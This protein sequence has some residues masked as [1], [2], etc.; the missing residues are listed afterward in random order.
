MNNNELW[1]EITEAR[2]YSVSN[3]G[4]IKSL[5]RVVT[6]S[7]GTQITINTKILR[8]KSISNSGYYRIQLSVN[9]RNKS[10]YIHRLVAEY[11]VNNPNAITTAIENELMAY[12]GIDD[13]SVFFEKLSL[14]VVTVSQKGELGL[15]FGS[16]FDDEV[17]NRLNPEDYFTEDFGIVVYPEVRILHNEMECYVFNA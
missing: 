13:P 14:D 12:F 4:R 2:G 7:N 9:G 1:K 17:I 5:R 8:H 6:T 3:F 16:Q 11:F 15:E 10:F